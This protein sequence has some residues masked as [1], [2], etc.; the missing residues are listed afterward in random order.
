MVDLRELG[1]LLLEEP[2]QPGRPA[3]VA[4][5]SGLVRRG[6]RLY[7][8]ADDEVA[9]AVFD[10]D[11]RGPGRLLLLEQADLPL[12]EAERK[13]RKPDLESLTELPPSRRWS[14]GA[15]LA[16]GSGA[17]GHRERGWIWPLRRDGLCGEPIEVSL[18][19]L[20][21][22]LRRDLDDLNVEGAAVLGERLWLAQ[23]GNGAE[24]ANV[25][26][27]LD[28]GEALAG[29]EHHGEL[30]SS[31]LRELHE[32]ELG[33]ADGVPLTFSDLAPL[34][35]G[36]LLFCAVAEDTASTYLDGPCVGA[37]L[38]ALE[39]PAGRPVLKPLPVPHK[40]EGVSPTAFGD[41][42]LEAL[43]V[44]DADDPSVAAPL[45]EARASGLV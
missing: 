45:L 21:G 22:A 33:E 36:R 10:Q 42:R 32:H 31:A 12:D 18:S 9:L 23:R 25:L 29:L 30:P 43:L 38:G 37:A 44:P 7:V 26:V 35:D 17:T 4:A 34:P 16:L 14:E 3:H 6:G 13:A 15:L 27:E 1:D 11:G 40:I 5:A 19:D 2:S 39:P 28:S 24:G 41:G 20:Y 8:V